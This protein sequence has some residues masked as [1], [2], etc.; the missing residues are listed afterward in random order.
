M[1]LVLLDVR[2]VLIPGLPVTGAFL[3]AIGKRPLTRCL[4]HLCSLPPGS[5]RLSIALKPPCHHRREYGSPW[6]PWECQQSRSTAPVSPCR[7]RMQLA[8]LLHSNLSWGSYLVVCGLPSYLPPCSSVVLELRKYFT[9][10]G[11]CGSASEYF[12]LGGCG[13]SAMTMLPTDRLMAL[14]R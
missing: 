14:M 4:H 1:V 6:L 8:C 7:R 5:S 13:G 2:Q 10:G 9:L 11:C 3:E 12:S